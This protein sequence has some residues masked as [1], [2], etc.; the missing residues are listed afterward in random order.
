MANNSIHPGPGSVYPGKYQR[1][2]GEKEFSDEL[3]NT[4]GNVR[5]PPVHIEVFDNHYKID[6]DIPG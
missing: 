4:G 5:N 6:M 1:A 3:C 2:W